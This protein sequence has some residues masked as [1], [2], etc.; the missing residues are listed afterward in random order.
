MLGDTSN[1]T[2]REG[3]WKQGKEEAKVNVLD[4][5]EKAGE[6]ADKDF[7]K[8]SNG[9]WAVRVMS[10]DV[11]NDWIEVTR[12]RKSGRHRQVLFM[13]IRMSGPLS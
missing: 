2:G 9:V 7:G 12:D 8:L 3:S 10:D 6:D 13:P 4:E 5:Q 11:E 1:E